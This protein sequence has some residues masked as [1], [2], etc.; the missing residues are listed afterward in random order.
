[1]FQRNNSL[2]ILRNYKKNMISIYREG[3]S[4]H[5]KKIGL[6]Y[7]EQLKKKMRRK[8]KMQKRKNRKDLW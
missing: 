5:L 1:M 6:Y 7:Q 2:I 3:N 4:K 8:E